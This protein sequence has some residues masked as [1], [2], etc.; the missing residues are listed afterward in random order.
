MVG[1]VRETPG[2]KLTVAAHF[3][4]AIAKLSPTQRRER[5]GVNEAVRRW[6]AAPPP[7][8]SGD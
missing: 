5:T 3:N 7:L 6:C 8:G 2:N 4:D 1:M